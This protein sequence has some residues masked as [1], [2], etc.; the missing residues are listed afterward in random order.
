MGM[1]TSD[2]WVYEH[3]CGCVDSRRM[4]L[5]IVLLVCGLQKDRY[6]DRFVGMWMAEERICGLFC[7]WMNG[8]LAVWVVRRWV[9]E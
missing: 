3:F 8:L 1:R 7:E 2:G 6:V 4:D 9:D 5:W